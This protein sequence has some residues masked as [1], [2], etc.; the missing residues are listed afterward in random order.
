MVCLARGDWTWSWVGFRVYGLGGGG[1]HNETPSE[2]LGDWW[3][4]SPALAVFAKGPHIRAFRYLTVMVS[5]EFQ[6]SPTPIQSIVGI[7]R[8]DIFASFHKEAKWV[9]EFSIGLKQTIVS[10]FWSP[11]RENREIGLETKL[12]CGGQSCESR[13]FLLWRPPRV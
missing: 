4:P 1:G 7:L 6:R 13:L 5:I 10:I 2:I 8:G 11:F 3:P 9:V 12:S